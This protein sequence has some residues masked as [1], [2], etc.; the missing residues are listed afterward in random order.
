MGVQEGSPPFHYVSGHSDNL[1][2]VNSGKLQHLQKA[3]PQQNVGMA[4][5]HDFLVLEGHGS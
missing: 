1:V 3:P 4:S 5:D 2:G